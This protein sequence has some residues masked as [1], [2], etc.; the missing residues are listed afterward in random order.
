MKKHWLAKKVLNSKLMYDDFKPVW[1]Q[2]AYFKFI[3]VPLVGIDLLCTEIR[4]KGHATEY[5]EFWNDVMYAIGNLGREDL[6][7]NMV[8]LES[9]I[10]NDIAESSM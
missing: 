1:L 4:T 9:K 5:D 6:V 3:S 8:S 2:R 7:N 10:Q